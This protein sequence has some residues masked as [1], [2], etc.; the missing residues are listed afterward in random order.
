MIYTKKKKFKCDDLYECILIIK[1]LC[2]F[3]I[4]FTVFSL[5]KLAK[6]KLGWDVVYRR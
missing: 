5:G 4:Q 6:E 1:Q 3:L 2:Q